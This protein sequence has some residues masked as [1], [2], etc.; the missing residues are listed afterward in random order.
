MDASDRFLKFAAECE[1]MAKVARTRE[2]KTEWHGMAERWTRCAKFIEQQSS[3]HT[4]GPK[5][6]HRKATRFSRVGISINC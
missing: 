3:A 6:R 1:L 5:R 4:G 2:S